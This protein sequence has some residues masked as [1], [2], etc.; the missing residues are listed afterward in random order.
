MSW[1]DKLLLMAGVI[2][3]ALL[4]L[5]TSLIE[6]GMKELWLTWNGKSKNI[7]ANQ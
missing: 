3:A 5:P 4:W 1:S 7:K 6:R 2:G